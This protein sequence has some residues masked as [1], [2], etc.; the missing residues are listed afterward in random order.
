MP[1]KV[2]GKEALT[3]FQRALKISPNNIAALAGAAQIEYQEG[4]QTAMPLLNHLLQLRPGDPTAHAMLAVLEYRQGHCGAA[5]PHFEKA[6]QLLD[7]QLDALHALATCLVRLKRLDD[8]AATFQR[9]VALSSRRSAGTSPPGIHSA[10]GTQAR[11]RTFHAAAAAGDQGS[12]CEHPAACFD[13]RGIRWKH[14]P[15]G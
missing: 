11:G 10:Y 1:A 13:C 5:V 2:D 12:G 6:G 4:N 7:S 15:G 8:A 14:A 9:A 3:S